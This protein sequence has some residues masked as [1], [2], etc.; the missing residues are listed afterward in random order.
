[1]PVLHWV[2]E[3]F[4]W[5]IKKGQRR[6]QTCIKLLLAH[7]REHRT[8]VFTF[9]IDYLGVTKRL[10]VCCLI[11]STLSNLSQ[12]MYFL[13]IDWIFSKIF[14]LGFSSHW[15]TRGAKQSVVEVCI[16][17]IEKKNLGFSFVKDHLLREPHTPHQ[18]K[19]V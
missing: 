14:Q 18:L 5:D 19:L 16:I 17:S 11:C 1:M 4:A 10:L 13:W 2:W 15:Q 3:G 7:F 6:A 8:W 12:W 9:Q